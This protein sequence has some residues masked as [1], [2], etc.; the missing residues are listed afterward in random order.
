MLQEAPS[1]RPAR[2]RRSRT[3]SRSGS[4]TAASSL[5]RRALPAAPRA[6]ARPGRPPARARRARR[7]PRRPRPSRCSPASASTIASALAL[8]QLAQPRVDVAAHAHHLEVG[9]RRR[10]SGRRGAGCWSRPGA[11]LELGQRARAAD[12]VAR[13]GALGD[14]HQLQPVGQLSRHVLGRV[15]R[16]RRSGPSSSARS[17]SDTHRDLSPTD[18]PRSP[19]VVIVTISASSP[20]RSATHSAC[21]S[22]SALPRVPIRI[23]VHPLRPRR[24][25][26]ARTSA[27]GWRSAAA[28]R[29]GRP[30]PRG[31]TGRGPAPPA[32]GRG[33]RGAPQPRGRVVQ[34][35]VDD[36][37]GD[38][39]D[40]LE[41]A[42]G[43]RLPL[44]VVLAQHL[45]GDLG[46]A[47]CAAPRSSAAPR[48]TQPGRELLDLL[49]DDSLGLARLR[50]AHPAV[51]GDH[52]LKVVD[53]VERHAVDV[54]A[55]GVDVARDR[56]IDQQQ[57]PPPRGRP[58][59]GPARAPRAARAARRSPR[60]RCR[61]CS[62]A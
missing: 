38:R 20:R 4:L 55:G 18:A 12:R 39:V 42:R 43:G 49:L 19:E 3:L 62:S 47:S 15:R 61:R 40:P 16:R 13:I 6:P 41:V 54:A 37:P 31:R 9:A 1:A 22:A 24:S 21:A 60:R 45:L 17:S 36:R 8:G 2:A 57:R 58:S 28:R 23:S 10:G 52:R 7:R 33:R 53:V 56:Q 14:R 59:P 44:A 26:I 48:A 30:R 35:P 5:A 51:A 46:R 25:E 11:G 34:Q 32:R 50:L 29:S 27:K